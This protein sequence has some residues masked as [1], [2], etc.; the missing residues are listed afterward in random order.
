[1]NRPGHI[2]ELLIR[3]AAPDDADELISFFQ[4]LVDEPDID[5]PIAPGEIHHTVE[6][7]KRILEEHASADNSIFFVA[8]AKG[9]IIGT[10]SCKGGSRK[11]LRHAVMLGLAVSKEWR[12]RGAGTALMSTAI[13]WAGKTGIVNRIELA[14]YARN[15][16]AIHLYEKLGFEHEGRRRRAIY[17]NGQYFDDLFMALLL[18]RDK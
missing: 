7:E 4:R 18:Q 9:K 6:E 8:E 2:K 3:E 13:E 15:K 16:T 14:V 10:L 11:A 1:M 5:I 17:Q 12:N